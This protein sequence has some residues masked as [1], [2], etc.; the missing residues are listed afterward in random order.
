MTPTEPNAGRDWWAAEDAPDVSTTLRGADLH[1][2]ARY[3]DEAM[4]RYQALADRVRA[5]EAEVVDSHYRLSTELSTPGD[6][7]CEVCEKARA[8]LRSGV[9]S[10]EGA[11]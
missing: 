3:L 2:E 6:C 7:D 4:R 9:P 11:E 1:C 10:E 8:A 5:L